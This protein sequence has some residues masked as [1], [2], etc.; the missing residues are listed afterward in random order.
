MP[1]PVRGH[2]ALLGLVF[3]EPVRPRVAAL[4]ERG[5]IVGGSDVPNVMRLMP[6]IH[7]SL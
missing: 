3:P 2:G 6:E 5:F 1:V 4:R 7:R